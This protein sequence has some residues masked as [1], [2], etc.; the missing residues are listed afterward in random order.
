MPPRLFLAWLKDT[1][2]NLELSDINWPQRVSK[3]IRGPAGLP[4]T[5]HGVQALDSPWLWMRNTVWTIYRRWATSFTLAPVTQPWQR[6]NY[7]IAHPFLLLHMDTTVS[8]GWETVCPLEIKMC[9]M[10]F[11]SRGTKCIEADVKALHLESW[12]HGLGA[13]V[14]DIMSARRVSTLEFFVNYIFTPIPSNEPINL[15]LAS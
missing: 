3:K 6:Y 12:V 9:L 14:T 13:H 7:S 15:S 2:S 11:L 10:G 1:A 5:V 4:Y 8:S